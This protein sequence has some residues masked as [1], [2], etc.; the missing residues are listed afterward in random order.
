[1]KEI[2]KDETLL[3]MVITAGSPSEAWKILLSLVGESSDAA[4]DRVKKKFEKLSFEIAKES[5]R[6]YI[7]RAKALVMKL[8]QNSVSTTKKEFNRQILNGLPSVF[9]VEKKPF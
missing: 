9:D 5:I 1:M 7:A 6:D 8:K 4:Q 3:D 2:E